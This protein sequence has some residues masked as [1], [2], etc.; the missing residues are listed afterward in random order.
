MFLAAAMGGLIV[1]ILSLAGPPLARLA[2]NLSGKAADDL[3][4]AFAFGA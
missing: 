1:M 3:G 4:L 2:F